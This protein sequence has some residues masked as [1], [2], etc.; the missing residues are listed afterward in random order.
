MFSA[1]QAL[2]FLAG[3]SGSGPDW[4]VSVGVCGWV[5]DRDVDTGG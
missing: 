5:V 4:C 3:V 2:L 1:A